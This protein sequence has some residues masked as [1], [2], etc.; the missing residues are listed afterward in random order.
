MKTIVRTLLFLFLACLTAYAPGD[1]APDPQSKEGIAWASSFEAAIEEAQIEGRVIMVDFY[2]SWCGWCRRL[3]A[4]TYS[5]PDVIARSRRIVCVKVDAEARKDLA[6]RY[7]VR[8]YPMIAFL[9]GD[10]TLI[11]AVRGYM[12]PDKFA[13]VLDRHIENR[14]SE[15]TL[16]QRLKDHPELVDVR[17]DLARI[18]LRNGDAAGALAEFDTIRRHSAD[19]SDDRS[20]EV[21]LDRGRA[22]L[23]VG[24]SEDAGKEFEAFVK[25][26][27]GSPRYAE[28]V[29][30][31]AEA[32]LAQGERKDARKWFR[33][34]L[35][36]RSSGWL[37][38]RSRERLGELG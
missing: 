8:A 12:P 15:F 6:V 13:P 35:Q 16:I 22:L 17:Y 24:R 25:K 26:R 38:D 1:A 23:R 20:W 37:A 18:L 3:D 29:Y 27:K 7:A 10:G 14:G 28:A 19:L 36:V 32:R 2:T 34:L 21:R 9:S 33:K 5:H 4:D 31:L 11:D 30:F